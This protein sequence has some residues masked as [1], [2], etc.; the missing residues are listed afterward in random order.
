MRR[1]SRIASKVVPAAALD[2]GL[3]VGD[4]RRLRAQALELHPD[5]AAQRLVVLGH[6]HA[7][8][9]QRRGGLGGR[10]RLEHARL[11]RQLE[12][13]R[14][15]RAQLG[16]DGDVAA[17]RAGEPARDAEPEAGPGPRA[18]VR[19]RPRLEQPLQVLLGD[20]ATGV[21]DRDQDALAVDARADAGVAGLGVLDGVGGEVEDDLAHA[22]GV[23]AQRVRDLGVDLDEQLE[24]AAAQAR[25]QDAGD[26]RQQPPRVVVLRLVLGAPG[27]GAGDVERV[28]H[29]P[30][31]RLRGVG[32]HDRQL[33]LASP[34]GR[35][36]RAA[37]PRPRCP[38]A[39]S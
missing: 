39:A 15:A 33:A 38:T 11:Q 12:R 22:G 18:R 29:E 19:A 9:G 34:A 10:D 37:R 21:G 20:A 32:D 30:A 26:R 27:L 5:Q 7:A 4:E 28:A 8:G 6:Q 31:E 17:H 36:R 35:R 23:A 13:E 14:R 3:A 1:S 2:G 16:D 25:A 24:R